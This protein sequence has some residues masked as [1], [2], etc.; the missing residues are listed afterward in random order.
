MTAGH[1]SCRVGSTSRCAACVTSD[2]FAAQPDRGPEQPGHVPGPGVSPRQPYARGPTFPPA[3]TTRRN[4]VTIVEDRAPLDEDK[5]NAFVFRAV[6]EVGAT[7][8]AALVVMGDRLGLYRALA[9]AGALTPTEVAAR[10]EHVRALRPRVA[11]RPG[12][13][14]I[15]RVRPRHL[16][17]H[18]PA[19]AGERPDGREQPGI[20]PRVLPDRARLGPRLPAAS[21]RRPAAARASAGTTTSTTC[22]RAASASSAP[23]TTRT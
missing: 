20:P 21:P 14:R 3:K 2:P 7:L 12:R 23:A 8:N 22:T 11:Q 18:A 16:P 19:R 4:D 9:G 13:G 17:V 6:E 10:T 5:L 1:S 15:R